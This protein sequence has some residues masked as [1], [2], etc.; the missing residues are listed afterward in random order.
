MDA[1]DKINDKFLFERYKSGFIVG[2]GLAP[3][4]KL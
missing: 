4:E 2:R 3:A 1:S